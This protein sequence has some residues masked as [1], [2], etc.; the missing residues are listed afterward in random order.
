MLEKRTAEEVKELLQRYRKRETGITR[1]AFCENEAISLS[2]LD[3]YLRRRAVP[4]VQLARVK[5][6]RETAAES[7]R[8]A[9]VLANGRRIECGVQEL[10]QL[11]AAAERA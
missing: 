5:V 1:R 4:A 11:I 9:L 10:V 7:G 6:T 2:M 8:Y 3:Y